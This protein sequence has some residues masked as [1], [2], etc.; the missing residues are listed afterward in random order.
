MAQEQRVARKSESSLWNGAELDEREYPV[1]VAWKEEAD[2]VDGFLGD[3]VRTP[4]ATA[5]SLVSQPAT[6]KSTSLILHIWELAQASKAPRHVL[7]VVS[8]EVEARFI[9]A[10]LTD[11]GAMD[12]VAVFGPQQGGRYIP[13]QVVTMERFIALA[14]Q[15]NPWPN[16]LTVAFDVNWYP[17]VDDE[18]A[19]SILVKRAMEVKTAVTEMGK[20]TRMAIILLMSGYVSS[21]TLT[22]FQRYLGHVTHIDLLHRTHAYPSTGELNEGWG[23]PGGRLDGAAMWL[24]ERKMRLAIDDISGYRG[25]FN[26]YPAYPSHDLD[27]TPEDAVDDTILMLRDWENTM[28]TVGVAT[29]YAVGLEAVGMVVLTGAKTSARVIDPIIMQLVDIERRMSHAEAARIL[30]WGTRS[31]AFGKGGV[32]MVAVPGINNH[33]GSI[34]DDLGRSWNEDLPIFILALFKAWPGVRLARIPIRITDRWIAAD[35]I[36]RLSVLG[37]AVSLGEGEEQDKVWRCT[38]LGYKIL[39]IWAKTH[40]KLDFSIIYLLAKV[41]MMQQRDPDVSS[42]VARVLVHMAAIAYSGIREFVA[43]HRPFDEAA[44]VECFPPIIPESRR[45][46]GGLW[47]ALALYLRYRND[48]KQ[49]E[50]PSISTV[51]GII[52]NRD[53]GG[54]ITKNLLVF[55]KLVMAAGPSSAGAQQDWY[56]LELGE[57]EIKAI[58]EELMWAW[59]HRIAWCKRSPEPG[60][61]ESVLD[62]VS[63]AEFKLKASN[64]LMDAQAIRLWLYRRSQARGAFF[65]IYETLERM[66]DAHQDLTCRGM[67]WIPGPTF[68]RAEDATG[69]EW[70]EMVGCKAR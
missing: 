43:V 65:A 19:I 46:A 34:R 23:E 22:M 16:D 18:M 32:T 26:I 7:Y 49:G 21:R 8:T 60:N 11:H 40:K 69:L 36:R 24:R 10:W 38:D 66:G 56:M 67:T 57:V 63:L 48:F 45:Q 9:R 29:P 55:E 35:R 52:V 31:T 42:L 28:V 4:G 51:N 39:E 70:P 33:I 58:D 47:V 5:L 44:L 27:E 59:L 64:E 30:S 37:C 53:C 50:G 12:N 62:M 54:D 61:V 13:V 2:K 68:K 15:E 25:E 14:L 3:A 20:D 1:F 6:G 17:T 41:A